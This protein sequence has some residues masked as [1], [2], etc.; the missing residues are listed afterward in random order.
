MAPTIKAAVETQ[1]VV[2]QAPIFN[3]SAIDTA[4]KVLA[5]EM[6]L[7]VNVPGGMPAYRT[8]LAVSFLYKFF[9]QVAESL[10]QFYPEEPLWVCF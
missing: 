7:P 3:Q 6:A 4:C 10:A 5:K 8:T 9:I 2:L 1:N